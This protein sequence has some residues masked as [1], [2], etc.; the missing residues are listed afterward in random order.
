V[1]KIVLTILTTGAL[2]TASAAKWTG[3]ISDAKCGKAHADASEKSQACVKKCTGAG[4]AAVFVVGDKVYTFDA[5]SA[6]GATI[7]VYVPLL[8]AAIPAAILII[9]EARLRRRSRIGYCPSCG[10]DCRGLPAASACP[11]CGH[12][13]GSTEKNSA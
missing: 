2:F 10:Y 9:I 12:G 6:N 5:K 1:N 11:E 3:T 13:R 7:P 8:F 4:Q